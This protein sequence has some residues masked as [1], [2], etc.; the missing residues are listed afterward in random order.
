MNT[1]KFNFRNLG[2]GLGLR[3][4][5]Y[6]QVLSGESK[7]NWFEV[8]SENFLGFSD[9]AVGGSS[10]K[11]LLKIR[12]NYPIV[13][14]GV[15]MSI[16]GSDPMN[17]SYLK[18][19]KQLIEIVEPEWVSDHLCWTGV[20]GRNLHDLLPLPY[21]KETL[22]H[23]STRILQVQDYLQRPMVIENVSSYVEFK[24]S[25]MSEWKFV[26]E[27]AKTS[28]CGLLCDIN[29]I[30]VS[31]HNHQNNPRDYIDTLP[32]EH[33]VQYHL[34]GPSKKGDLF[35]DTHSGPMMPEAWKIYEYAL[36]KIGH[37]STMIEWDSKI[38]SLQRLE[39]E[40]DKAR[41]LFNRMQKPRK[42]VLSNEPMVS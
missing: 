33:I 30:F 18:K 3:P 28:N 22:Q 17:M 38:P 10:L 5:H 32:A 14:H 31:A 8:I 4:P 42:E 34:A 16:G 1:S 40:L 36:E 29:N 25:T 9:T 27:L 39:A 13:L 20:H 12:E 37:R 6:K 19:L 7:A 15:S 2:F 26:A 35:I 21:T 11:R 23:V 41:I 24:E